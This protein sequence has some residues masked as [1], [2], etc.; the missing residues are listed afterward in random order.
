MTDTIRV[1]LRTRG[2]FETFNYYP[3]GTED[4]IELY[5]FFIKGW[6]PGSFHRSMFANDLS[7]AASHSHVGNCWENIMAVMKWLK[8]YVPAQYW[9]NSAAID[10]WRLIG[11]EARKRVCI[12]L[13]WVLTDKELAWAMLNEKKVNYD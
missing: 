5:N 6:E 9:G 2:F 13:G 8:A 12:D 10:N 1:D 4:Q 7:G 11:N 3:V